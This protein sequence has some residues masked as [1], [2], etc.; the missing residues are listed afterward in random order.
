MQR[1]LDVLLAHEH[2]DPER[3]AVT[4][5]SG[6]GWQTILLSALDTRV[7]LAAPNAGYIGLDVRVG[8]TEDIG[9]IEQNPTDLA[10]IADYPLLTAMLA[11]RPSLLLY[12]RTDDCCFQTHRAKPSVYDPVRPLFEAL[13]KGDSFAFHDNQDPGTHNYDVDNRQQFYRFL[14]RHF[15]VDGTGMA[16]EIPSQNEVRTAEELTVGL[17]DKREDFITLAADFAQHL[18]RVSWPHGDP[19]VVRDW[20][21]EAKKRLADVL[22]YRVPVWEATESAPEIVT[23]ERRVKR[24]V[25]RLK[26]GWHIPLVTIEGNSPDAPVCVVTADTGMGSATP[27]IESLLAKDRTVIAADLLFHGVCRSSVTQAHQWAMMLS[28][29]GD[30]TLGIQTVQLAA[31]IAHAGQSDKTVE[32]VGVGRLCSVVALTA[33]A[34]SGTS[35]SQVT[36]REC[37]PTLKRLIEQATPY[38]DA[39]PL[40]C[41]GLLET[42]DIRELVGLLAPT[43]VDIFCDG[44]GTELLR[45]RELYARFGTLG[46]GVH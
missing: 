40:F 9:D 44:N 34:L 32:V 16:D 1:G 19:A 35:V 21:K 4:G 30:R 18:P 46:F 12:N 15:L 29:N 39:A 11:P 10:T 26:D 3:L 23:E 28:A 45:L 7:K 25:L 41:F 33:S 38:E 27:V 36:L 17:P 37:L 8:H 42:F 13:G 31:V 22:R 43:P 5:L 2:T 20:Q 24:S 14:N 6:G